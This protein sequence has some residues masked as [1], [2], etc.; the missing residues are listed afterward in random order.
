MLNA[1][2]G[3]LQGLLRRFEEAKGLVSLLKIEPRFLDRLVRCLWTVPTQIWCR[4][5]SLMLDIT[6]IITLVRVASFNNS[7]NGYTI[8]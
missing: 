4:L 7:G 2:L 1:I 3:M 6:L 5:M 8:V